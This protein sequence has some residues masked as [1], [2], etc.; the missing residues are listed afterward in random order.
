MYTTEHWAVR[1]SIMPWCASGTSWSRATVFLICLILSSPARL[2]G[3]KKN[4][5][6]RDPGPL[7]SALI[8]GIRQDSAMLD[9]I[10]SWV[11]RNI[12]YDHQAYKNGNKRINQSN[13]DILRRR[14]ALCLGYAN[15]IAEMCLHAGIPAVVVS[16]YSRGLLTSRKRYVAPDHAWNAVKLDEQWHLLD[17]TW[18]SGLLSSPDEFAA[19]YNADYFLTDP[20]LLILNHLPADPLW[21]LIHCTVSME[22]FLKGPEAIQARLV[23]DTC[24]SDFSPNLWLAQAEDQ[25]RFEALQRTYAF[26]PTPLNKK[27][28]GNALIDSALILKELGDEAF[29]SHSPVV[30]RNRYER[31]IV[32]FQDELLKAHQLQDWQKEG[33]AQAHFQLGQILYNAVPAG[34]SAKIARQLQEA[35]NCFETAREI[36]ESVNANPLNKEFLQQCIQTEQF[37]R[38]QLK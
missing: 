27:E 9:A 10:Y 35:L 22:L 5:S 2:V 36:M 31:A 16:G 32:L 28:L 33:M 6:F 23:E 30:A 25:R 4:T 3:Q 38:D 8:E 12:E 29:T 15:L 13:S 20:R 7:T 37:V 17:A 11:I 18:G 19:T 26:H 1:F 14:K 24:T 34:R 21:Q